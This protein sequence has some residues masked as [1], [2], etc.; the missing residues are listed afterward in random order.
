MIEIA[1]SEDASKLDG[2]ESSQ[3]DDIEDYLS[4]SK[5]KSKLKR[6]SYLKGDQE[7]DP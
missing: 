3:D 2:V 7:Q 5:I 1:P 6:L 4:D